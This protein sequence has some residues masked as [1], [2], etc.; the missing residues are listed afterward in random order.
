MI[1]N[2]VTQQ[3]KAKRFLSLHKQ[4]K[5][6]ILPNIWDPLGAR[7]LEA[8]G[9]PAAATTSAAISSS[10]GCEDH[11]NIKL[12]THLEIIRRIVN[13]VEIPVSADFEGGYAESISDLK[14]SIS[15]VLETG[16]A[17]INIEDNI[18]NASELR[19]SGSSAK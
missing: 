19:E 7:M 8:E 2:K 12:S 15:R 4:N 18:N 11:E 3:E 10:L 9:F 17:G 16:V 6:L 1:I 14:D 13:S 5:I